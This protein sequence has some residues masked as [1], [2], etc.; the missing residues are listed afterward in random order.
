MTLMVAY[1]R[2]QSAMSQTIKS[3]LL[4]GAELDKGFILQ[5]L[6]HWTKVH[7]ASGFQ[8]ESPSSLRVPGHKP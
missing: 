5:P 6:G 4:T 1:L 3:S 2:G 8:D 7:S